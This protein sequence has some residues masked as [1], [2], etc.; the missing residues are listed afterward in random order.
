MQEVYPDNWVRGSLIYNPETGEIHALDGDLGEN[1]EYKLLEH[2]KGWK[3][4]AVRSDQVSKTFAITTS[5]EVMGRLERFFALLHYNSNFGHSSIFGMCLDG[6]GRDKVV[7]S[8]VDANLAPEVNA[9][10]GVGYH[11]ELAGD[12]DY[13]GVFIDSKKSSKWKTAPPGDLLK[14]GDV[15]MKYRLDS[16]EKSIIIF[17]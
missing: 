2:V 15:I 6:D 7:V 5:K 12:T 8:D 1:G 11:V 3:R 13:S 16:D 14:D 9:I 10:G 17:D 4:E